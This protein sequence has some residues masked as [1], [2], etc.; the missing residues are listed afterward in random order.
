LNVANLPTTYDIYAFLAQLASS[1]IVKICL[2][3][4]VLTRVAQIITATHHRK[5]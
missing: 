5:C 2:C 4:C 1:A 3:V